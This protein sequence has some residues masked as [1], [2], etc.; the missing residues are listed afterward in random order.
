MA[1]APRGSSS[2]VAESSTGARRGSSSQSAANVRSTSSGKRRDSHGD[3]A[4]RENNLDRIRETG[5]DVRG[6]AT[7]RA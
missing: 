5:Q 4:R 2:D 3:R 6:G 1:I 7:E